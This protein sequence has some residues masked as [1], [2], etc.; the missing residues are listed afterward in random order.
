MFWK[1]KELENDLILAVLMNPIDED[2]AEMKRLQFIMDVIVGSRSQNFN[3]V[4]V[5]AQDSSSIGLLCLTVP[6]VLCSL[7]A[8][9]KTK[10]NGES[11]P[12]E[13]FENAKSIKV[14]A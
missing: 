3:F 4:D 8:K 11:N 1:C 7:G 14:A 10:R 13:C 6:H 2:E 12:I 5:V 9:F